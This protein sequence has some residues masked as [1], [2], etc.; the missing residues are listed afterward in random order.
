MEMEKRAKRWRVGEAE[1]WRE[2]EASRIK[3]V[4]MVGSTAL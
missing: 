3:P 2:V 1:R 4:P